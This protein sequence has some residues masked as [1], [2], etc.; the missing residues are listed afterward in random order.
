ML[1]MRQDSIRFIYWITEINEREGNGN[2]ICNDLQ[3]ILRDYQSIDN[4]FRKWSRLTSNFNSK[5]VK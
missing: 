1:K 3:K 2:I 5:T 4:I